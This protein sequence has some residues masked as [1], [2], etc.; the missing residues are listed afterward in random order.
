[1]ATMETSLQKVAGFWV[2]IYAYQQDGV[3]EQPPLLF[4]PHQKIIFFQNF[5]IAETNGEAHEYALQ[6]FLESIDNGTYGTECG[7]D[8]KP[9]ISHFHSLEKFYVDTRPIYTHMFVEV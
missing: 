5:I 1:M 6:Q 9:P 7:I 2:V 8:P 3:A 4:V